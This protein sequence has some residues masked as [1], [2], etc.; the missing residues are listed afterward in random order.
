MTLFWMIL[1][2]A[3]SGSAHAIRLYYRAGTLSQF[4]TSYNY[5]TGIL[6]LPLTEAVS[7][8]TFRLAR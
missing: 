5:V 6:G 7:E 3:L 4:M 8:D 2:I 1:I